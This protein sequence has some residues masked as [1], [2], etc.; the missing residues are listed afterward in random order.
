[1]EDQT[2]QIKIIN[3]LNVIAKLAPGF[4]LSTNGGLSII[5]HRSWYSTISRFYYQENRTNSIAY[6]KGI[7][8]EALALIELTN[9]RCLVHRDCTCITRQDIINHLPSAIKS[10]T[11]L[12]DTYKGDY[13][14]ISEIDK[15]IEHV[16]SRL[17]EL[18]IKYNVGVTPEK[19]FVNQDDESE[20]PEIAT[21][22]SVTNELVEIPDSTES[23]EPSQ[24]TNDIDN[25]VGSSEIICDSSDVDFDIKFEEIDI[26]ELDFKKSEDSII[27]DD[28]IVIP[29]L[30]DDSIPEHKEI[31]IEDNAQ[32]LKKCEQRELRR[33]SIK[34]RS[35][36]DEPIKISSELRRRIRDKSEDGK[37]KLSNRTSTNAER[38]QNSPLGFRFQKA[39]EKWYDCLEEF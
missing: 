25:Q 13:Y 11:Y 38:E 10:F 16:I 18:K 22:E 30:L 32:F 27:V 24:I 2:R 3:D 1:M 19:K 35:S 33:E 23:P 7:L 6:I 5:D 9:D 31:I 20:Q 39:F 12:K 29:E 28:I 15:I 17:K 4:S 36:S 14:A 21:D 26:S 37:K 34:S 8:I